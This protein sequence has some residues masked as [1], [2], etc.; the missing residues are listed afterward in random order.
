MGDAADREMAKHAAPIIYKN[1]ISGFSEWLRTARRSWSAAFERS[2]CSG[3]A[4]G[5]ITA[6][7]EGKAL[8]MLQLSKEQKEQ[9]GLIL[10]QKDALIEAF[11]AKE[12]PKLGKI[13]T[14]KGW[15]SAEANAAGF[16]KGAGLKLVGRKAIA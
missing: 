11:K 8:A 16:G 7:E 6:S 13:R 14:K 12:F 3:V 1:M 10:V 15:G 9:F 4:A 2:Y 5:Y